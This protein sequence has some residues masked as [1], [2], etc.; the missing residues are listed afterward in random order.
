MQ[1]LLSRFKGTAGADHKAIDEYLDYNFSLY[2]VEAYGETVKLIDRL[3]DYLSG[4]DDRHEALITPL[5]RHWLQRKKIFGDQLSEWQ[6][7]YDGLNQK[8]TKARTHLY[9]Q[10]MEFDVMK[11]FRYQADELLHLL[12][13]ELINPPDYQ[14]ECARRVTAFKV[15]PE[16]DMKLTK[17]VIDCEVVMNAQC[18]QNQSLIDRRRQ[19]IKEMDAMTRD[20]NGL[21]DSVK[22]LTEKDKLDK[23]DEGALYSVPPVLEE[24][25]H[26]KN[27]V[28]SENRVW[29]FN[30]HIAPI[31]SLTATHI[32]EIQ[33]HVR[34]FPVNETLSGLFFQLRRIQ[35]LKNARPLLFY[36]QRIPRFIML[37]A[38]IQLYTK[39]T[40]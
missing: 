40:A 24:N 5:R 8:L 3:L 17:Q 1:D 32:A 15:R 13:H 27:W 37:Y 14:N 25:E 31:L 33:Q 35:S 34:D 18:A 11:M 12:E 9:A 7:V 26:V 29:E 21:R 39:A 6:K 19:L 30:S 10:A 4:V 23:N 16:T 28:I 36:I 38:L 2:L 20:M 22:Q